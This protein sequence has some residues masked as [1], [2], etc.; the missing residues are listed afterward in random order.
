MAR[1]LPSAAGLLIAL[2]T[3][4]AAAGL[5]AAQEEPAA[6]PPDPAPRLSEGRR[7]VVD[8]RLEEAELA[9]RDALDR[10][11]Q[12]DDRVGV[13]TALLEL[14]LVL[15][16]LGRTDEAVT[17]L[18]E[19]LP[20]ADA[21]ADRSA[22]VVVRVQLAEVQLRAGRLGEA[23]SWADAALAATVASEELG[24]IGIAGQA[25]LQVS[26]SVDDGDAGVRAALDFV[27]GRLAEVPGYVSVDQLAEAI[28]E[29]GAQRLARGD[30]P[31]AFLAMS[32]A[33]R[34]AEVT[35]DDVV[36]ADYRFGAG[37]AA[38]YLSLIHI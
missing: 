22:P 38:L 20:L 12:R 31:G 4:S 27:D 33:A 24:L 25:Y 13:R 9:L 8:G 11:R 16:D 36:L 5:A 34:I 28:Y 7:A 35:G 21:A 2:L 18:Q 37:Y 32:G 14:S 1:W 10:Y 30:A 17:L 23:L 3:A 29:L 26:R 19:A 15:S 6:L